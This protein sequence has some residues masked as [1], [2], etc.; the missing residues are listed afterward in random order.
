[1]NLHGWAALGG[2]AG[3]STLAQAWRP[4]QGHGTPCPL[5]ELPRKHSCSIPHLCRHL[6]SRLYPYINHY[7]NSYLKNIYILSLASASITIPYPCL[8]HHLNLNACLNLNPCR[9]NH[10]NLNHHLN[11]FINFPIY[12]SISI[13]FSISILLPVLN[14]SQEWFPVVAVDSYHAGPGCAA[15][16][17]GRPIGA[18]G[19]KAQLLE[20]LASAVTQL[21]GLIF[22][23]ALLVNAIFFSGVLNRQEQAA[24]VAIE[25]GTTHF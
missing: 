16:H 8:N 9:N 5:G 6:R 20:S 14:F 22:L 2:K 19:H 25:T 7:L 10:L 1:L 17:G 4:G 23:L 18:Q 12:I 24:F 21:M 3:L 13:P 11:S 15:R